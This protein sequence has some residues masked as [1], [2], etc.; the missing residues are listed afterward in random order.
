MNP[1]RHPAALDVHAAADAAKILRNLRF[2]HGLDMP[3]AAW[4]LLAHAEAKLNLE[5]NAY[6]RGSSEQLS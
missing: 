4:D 3:S 2:D 1:T 5:I 6:L